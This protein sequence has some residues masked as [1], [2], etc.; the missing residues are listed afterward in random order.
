MLSES[1]LEAIY[2]L[3]KVAFNPVALHLRMCGI[4][5]A[6]SLAADKAVPT[7]SRATT[8]EVSWAPPVGSKD[9]TATGKNL[10][11][12]SRLAPAVAHDARRTENDHL[13][14]ARLPNFHGT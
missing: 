10:S 8:S 3:L 7:L 13:Q 1:L 6:R 9:A 5:A 14:F 11:R 12:A 4:A 2:V